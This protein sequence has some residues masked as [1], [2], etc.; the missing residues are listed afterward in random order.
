MLKKLLQKLLLK[1]TSVADMEPYVYNSR[2][3][4]ILKKTGKI[5]RKTL[6]KV[7][8]AERK[9]IIYFIGYHHSK[10]A[11]LI[12][13]VHML[14]LQLRGA[15]I[16]VVRSSY[17]FQQE[18]II[19]G[20]AYNKDR[21]E[22]QYKLYTDEGKIFSYILQTQVI[23]I[24]AFLSSSDL[25]FAEDF[26]NNCNYEGWESITYD[27]FSVGEMAY[28]A[29]C[30]TNN[31]NI[32]DNS[33]ETVRQFKAHLRNCVALS[34][35]SQKLLTTIQADTVVSN[36]PFYYLWR[37]PFLRSQMLNIPFY[38]YMLS[39]RPNSFF[40]TNNSEKFCDSSKN[41]QSF[42]KSYTISEDILHVLNKKIHD[43]LYGKNVSEKRINE[44]RE[45][46]KGRS[47]VLLPC[48]ILSDAAVFQEK[49]SFDS[50]LEMIQSVIKWFSDNPQYFC[51]LKAHPAEKLMIEFGMDTSFILLG[52]VLKKCDIELP[53]NICFVDY[54][55]DVTVASLFG[56]VKGVIAYTSSV[57]MDAGFVGLPSVSVLESHYSVADFS[58]N[59]SSREDF[60]RLLENMLKNEI[61]D[62]E[63]IIEET[64]KYFLLYY[65]IGSID[66]NLI[67]GNDVNSVPFDIL[68]D[69]V[70]QLL[71][72][73]S[74]ALD[75]V[76]D[77][78]LNNRSIFGVDRRPPITI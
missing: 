78:I 69:S 74:E 24:G 28:H 64:R 32:P 23:E 44:I 18:D 16:I 49:R 40:W 76:C 72:G 47:A 14:A 51:I 15:E 21:F 9:K 55:E 31:V 63:S 42:K 4:D 48:N 45:L 5:A 68:F 6:E 61:N 60:F 43:K 56:L 46:V 3:D 65:C 1:N 26:A 52:S 62:R 8:P 50:C 19:F 38:S 77:A 36:V 17:F 66:Y 30:N 67:R 73:K 71:P 2:I 34:I 25:K 22:L 39:E 13:V 57:C 54:N 75:Y 10:F 59:P 53:E 27:G 35:A 41:W 12:D 37:I 7:S 11:S 70:D 33:T 58:R 29:I 20:G